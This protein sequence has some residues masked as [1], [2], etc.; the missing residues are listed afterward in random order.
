VT[1]WDRAYC[2]GDGDFGKIGDGSVTRRL[3]PVPVSGGFS[4]STVNA[5]NAHTCGVTPD[6]HAYCWGDNAN[7]QLGDGT[8]TNRVT[9]AAVAGGLSLGQAEAGV[10]YSCGVTTGNRTYCWGDNFAGALGDGTTT[11][12][13]R[14]V[15]VVGG[16]AFRGVSPG[17]GH[18]TCG[19][20]TLSLGYCWGHNAYGQLGNGT[21]TGPETCDYAIPCSRKPKQVVGPS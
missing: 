7:G 17:S 2:W 19:V 14:P 8:R 12:R 9:P 15:A 21:S 13:L 20:T 6:H 3:V 1:T 18:H 16:L 10:S 5:G 4:F 11:E